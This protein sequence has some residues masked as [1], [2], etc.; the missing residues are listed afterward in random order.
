MGKTGQIIQP[1][2]I[3]LNVYRTAVPDDPFYAETDGLP[4]GALS[5]DQLARVI[6]WEIQKNIVEKSTRGHVAED[7]I[8]AP[9]K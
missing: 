5:A 7:E 1:A 3:L 8:T 4:M 9:G 6:A 2:K